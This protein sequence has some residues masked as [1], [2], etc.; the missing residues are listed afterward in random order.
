MENSEDT[1]GS[2]NK[3][4]IALAGLFLLSSV[5]L[6]VMLMQSN[7]KIKEYVVLKEQIESE[8]NDIT[9]ELE[10]MFV[11]Y[12]TLSVEN[13]EMQSKIAEQKDK[14]ETLIKE[15]KNKNWTIRKLRKETESLREIMKSY[16]V[17]IDSLNTAN[18][19]LIAE[20]KQLTGELTKE[21]RE[22]S[23]LAREKGQLAQQVKIGSKLKALN[24]SSIG[25]K[26]RS[27]G[28][29]REMDRAN[30]VETIKTCFT[31][32]ENELTA[33]GPKVIHLRIITPKGRVLAESQSD[34]FLFEFEGVQGLYSLKRDIIYDN[35]SLDLCYYYKLKEGEVLDP[36]KYI[37][38]AYAQDYYIG[39]T[40]MELK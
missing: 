13:E 3:L 25:Q 4:W 6:G 26:I 17:T 22:K 20:K 40:T 38:E 23:A 10:E 9:E 36:G 21:R 14:I 5:I 16:L 35:E 2:N 39:N 37:I 7:A 18:Q 30:R 33:S 34:E 31:I 1:K 15:A 29:H 12:D 11:K 19:E 8:K 32:E 28:L 27:N 24:M